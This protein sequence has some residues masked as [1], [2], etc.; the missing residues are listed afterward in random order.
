M[1]FSEN[2]MISLGIFNLK[3][4]LFGAQSNHYWNAVIYYV[5]F[6]FR[7]FFEGA[8]VFFFF[9]G[10]FFLF[11]APELVNGRGISIG[12]APEFIII[13]SI[14]CC[15]VSGINCGCWLNIIGLKPN[16]K[17]KLGP[18]SGN[19]RSGMSEF[20]ISSSLSLWTISSSLGDFCLRIVIMFW[21]FRV[22]SREYQHKFG[23]H[24]TVQITK[25][26]Q[27]CYKK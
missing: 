1:G 5:L 19:S 13:Q 25:H 22:N 16:G 15:W 11:T 20:W 14:F 4:T 8:L 27:T 23:L 21:E 12:S 17:P 6:I 24:H 10:G 7:F 2:L 26:F 3:N 9:E 18:G